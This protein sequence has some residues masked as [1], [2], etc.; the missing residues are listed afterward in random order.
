M[1]NPIPKSLAAAEK[2]MA[3]LRAHS[4]AVSEADD[5]QEPI[6]KRIF[7]LESWTASMPPSSLAEAAIKL[8]RLADPEIG[9]DAGESEEDALSVRQVLAFI[10]VLLAFEQGMLSALEKESAAT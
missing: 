10:D 1:I 9:L 7:A 3:D 8:R 5:V 2:E 4:K 6:W